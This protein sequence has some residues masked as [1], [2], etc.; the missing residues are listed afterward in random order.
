[1][2]N[3]AII[4]FL[5]AF[6]SISAQSLDTNRYDSNNKKTGFW[7]EEDRY[8]VEAYY[9]NGK[10]HGLYKSYYRNTQTLATFGHFT[11]GSPT[12]IW[13][14]FHEN[15]SLIAVLKQVKVNTEHTYQG[16]GGNMIMPRYTSFLTEYHPNGQVKGEGQIIYDDFEIDFIKIGIWKC[17]TNK[18]VVIVCKD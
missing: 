14:Y 4:L 1:M 3:L 16:D 2:K 15:S 10:L 8:R 18:G 9:L 17:Y 7:I 12:G 6:T 11:N 13:Y 5:S